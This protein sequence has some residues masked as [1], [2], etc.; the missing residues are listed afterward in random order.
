VLPRIA[1]EGEKRRLSLIEG[2][3]RFEPHPLQ[4]AAIYFLDERR[5]DPAP[6]VETM[7]PQT[8]LLSLVA[9][10][11]AN[12]ILDRS[13]RAEEFGVLSRLVKTIPIRRV[14]SHCDSS[15]I[16]DLCRVIRED[17]SG[18]NTAARLRA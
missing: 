15:R 5:T 3:A 8:A 14:F 12:R 4:L 11:Y 17:Y 7:R 10:T 6:Y 16:R 18:L 9:D 1:P 2:E 13:L